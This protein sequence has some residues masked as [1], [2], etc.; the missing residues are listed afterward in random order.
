MHKVQGTLQWRHN[1]RDG[2]AKS[3]ASR[4]FTKRSVQAQIKEN[5]KALRHWLLW[6]EFTGDRWIPLTIG[7]WR[8]KCSI[9][10]RLMNSSYIPNAI[11]S[12]FSS[13]KKSYA[14][15]IPIRI[16]RFMYGKLYHGPLTRYVKLR[17]AHAPGMPGA[18]S[19]ADDF[20]G[21]R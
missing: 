20:K 6:G 3:Q 12:N 10:W 14:T 16:I 5:I 7:Q 17:V 2:V 21:N 15:Y 19:P 1:P 18:F 8:G 4:W 13:L 11:L 9:W